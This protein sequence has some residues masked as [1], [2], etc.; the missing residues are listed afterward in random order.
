MAKILFFGRL[1]DLAG[2]P[3]RELRLPDAI[4]T[5]TQLRHWLSTDNA[6]LGEALARPNVRTAINK[7]LAPMRGDFPI[8]DGDEIAFMPPMSGG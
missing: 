2:G 7:A 1:S 4:D 5:L 6:A 3:E 8:S